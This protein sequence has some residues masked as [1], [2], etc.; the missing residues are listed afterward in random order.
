MDMYRSAL[1]YPAF[2]LQTLERALKTIAQSAVA[3]I[4]AD[5]FDV[6][7]LD[8]AG[9]GSIALGAG[10]VS[11]LTSVASIPVGRDKDSPSTV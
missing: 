5:A 4:G 7:N 2:W 1:T 10:V 6:V 3:T 9:V 11:V 8:W